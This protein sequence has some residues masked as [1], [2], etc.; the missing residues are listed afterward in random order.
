VFA[1]SIAVALRGFL[2][3]FWRKSAD[4]AVALLDCM[5]DL[6]VVDREVL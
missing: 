2:Y 5:D 6:G 3:S 1:A 4:Y